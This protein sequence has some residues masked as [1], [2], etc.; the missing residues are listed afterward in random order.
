MKV[1]RIKEKE[2]IGGVEGYVRQ[3]GL[4]SFFWV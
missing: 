4:L 2:R 3:V 1:K